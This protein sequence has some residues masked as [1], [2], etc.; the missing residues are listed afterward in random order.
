MDG[1]NSDDAVKPEDIHAVIDM[2]CAVKLPADRQ[3]LH[4]VPQDILLMAVAALTTPGSRVSVSRFMVSV[5]A[6]LARLEALEACC[7]QAKLNVV[8]AVASP[9]AQG[10]ALLTDPHEMWVS[11]F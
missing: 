8:D 9:L 6:H 11:S 7:R 10:E 3:I 1:Q 4:V 5:T 2:A